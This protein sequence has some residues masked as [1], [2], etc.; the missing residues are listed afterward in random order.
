MDCLSNVFICWIIRGLM[1]CTNLVQF[2]KLWK[3]RWKFGLSIIGAVAD[4]LVKHRWLVCDWIIDWFVIWFIHVIYQQDI[5]D[6]V[7]FYYLTKKA[8]GYKKLQRQKYSRKPKM[9]GTVSQFSF[10]LTVLL[11]LSIWILTGSLIVCLIV[12]W[13]YL[14]RLFFFICLA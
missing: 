14:I 8:V 2:K 9:R 4:W 6:C 1:E 3:I 13:I 12:R 11:N 7:Q 10:F 5:S